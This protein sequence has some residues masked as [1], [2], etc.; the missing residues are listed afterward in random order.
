MDEQLDQIIPFLHNE[1]LE[2]QCQAIDIITGL[3]ADPANLEI[4]E[5]KNVVKE[6][7]KLLH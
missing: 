4:L 5:K 1:K 3:S 6:L 7:A 2:V